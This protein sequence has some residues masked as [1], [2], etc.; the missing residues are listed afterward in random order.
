VLEY[1]CVVK[2]V[3]VPSN[4]ISQPVVVKPRREDWYSAQAD[5]LPNL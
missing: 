2:S 1:F 3:L 4:P 5:D